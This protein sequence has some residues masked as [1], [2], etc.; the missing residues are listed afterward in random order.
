MKRFIAFLI[1]IFISAQLFAQAKDIVTEHYKVNG[2]CEQCKKR[3]E[4]AAYIKGVKRAEWD[5]KTHEL[6]VVYRP[7]KT[8]ADEIL[9]SVAKA[10]HDNEKVQATDEDYEHLPSCCY[11]RTI[12]KQ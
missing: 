11:Y 8:S 9:K 1:L 7:S 2:V 10:G 12:S 4:D 3:I 6:T 5:V